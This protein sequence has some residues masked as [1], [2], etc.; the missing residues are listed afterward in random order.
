MREVYQKI[1][2][3]ANK[4]ESTNVFERI[5]FLPGTEN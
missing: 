1:S 2:Y 4:K 3:K 5:L